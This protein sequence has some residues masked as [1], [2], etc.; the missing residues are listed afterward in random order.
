MKTL[1]KK[2]NV[3]IITTA[4]LIF[5][6]LLNTANAQNL[7]SIKPKIEEVLNTAVELDLFSGCV[8]VAKGNEV[9]FSGAYGE[10]N[11]DFHIMNTLDTKFNIASVTKT[12]T[13]VSIMLLVQ[14][15]LIS[16]N[17]P[18][19]KYLSDFPFGDKITIFHLLTHTSGLG[20]YTQEYAEKKHQIRGFY[21]FLNLFIYKEKL[22]FEAG[23]KFQY[24]NSGV[25]VLGAII[26][27]VSGLKYSDYLE[28]NIFAPLN[29]K[30][31]CNKMPEEIIENRAS[32]Y[33]RKLSGGF[34][35]TSLS[36]S[37]P[38][39]ATGLRTTVHDLF[40][41]FQAVHSNNLLKQEYKEIMF[42]PY[43]KD[44]KDPYALLWEVLDGGFYFK[45]N[46]PVIGHSGFQP[47]FMSACFYYLENK[48]T[49]IL[50]TNYSDGHIVFKPIEA[51]L[52]DKEYKLPRISVNSFLYSYVQENSFNSI[53]NNLNNILEK[54]H[55]TISSP[56][57]L[58]RLG[59]SLIHEGELALAIK[60]FILNVELF[61]DNANTYDS[62][63]EA[64]MKNDQKE[65]AIKN[66]E[67][68][69]ELNPE[70]EN[71]K[72]MLLQLRN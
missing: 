53:I 70:N 10:A 15:G 24:S 39:S 67:K 45:S 9:L 59:Y 58:N 3:C 68:S 11:K 57:T 65:L 18:V 12:F 61:N 29:M 35:E 46:N 40:T 30:N 60:F 72:E 49:L 7:E 41:F 1:R 16:L 14:N 4:V 5:C 71:A 34:F 19:T 6:G 50:L 43:L 22:L 8:L 44:G 48:Y 36:I 27:K 51:I 32:G 31:T 37:P 69:L 47:G 23:T 17:D 55:Y 38:T 63:A 28:Q 25:I 21:D 64:Y 56:Y 26:E 52:L 66:Y 13:S 2:V 42:T 20:H 62:L 33:T 54:N